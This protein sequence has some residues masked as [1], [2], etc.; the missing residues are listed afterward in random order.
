MMTKDDATSFDSVSMTNM[1]IVA[2]ELKCNCQPYIDVFT[3][4]RWT[5]QG[6]HVK[7]GEHGIHI[8]TF[9]PI[10]KQNE[11]G[12]VKIVGRVPKTSVVFCRCQVEKIE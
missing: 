10:K 12:E 1:I 9:V 7:K 11:N 2:T 3:Y 8:S 4:N 5:A 6:Y